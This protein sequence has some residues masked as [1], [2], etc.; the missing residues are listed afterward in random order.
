MN[1]STRRKARHLLHFLL[2]WVLVCTQIALPL[3]ALLAAVQP[4][5]PMAQA[6]AQQAGLSGWI[7]NAAG[8]VTAWAQ[9]LWGQPKTAAAQAPPVLQF[10]TSTTADGTYTNGA[11]IPICANYDLDLTIGSTLNVTLDTGATLALKNSGIAIGGTISVDSAYVTG[12]GP[13]SHVHALA[14][15]ADGK[16]IIGGQFT[17]Y[18]GTGRNRIARINTD[19][20]LDSSFTGS[21][22]NNYTEKIAIQADGKAIIVGH[23]TSVNGTGRNYIARLN[24]DGS[25]DTSFTPTLDNVPYAL[26]IQADGKI[27][28][29]GQ[30]GNVNG[31]GRT[32]LARLNSDGTLDTSFNPGSGLNNYTEEIV[33]QSDGKIVIGG[34]FTTVNG[35]SR[36]Y[37]ARLN[38]DGSLDTGFNPV[39]NNVPYAAALQS[40]GKIVFGG[41]FSTVNGTGRTRLARVNSDGTLDTSFDP[42]SGLNNYTEAILV[43]SDGQIIIGGHFTDIDGTARNR[44]AR[45]NANGSVDTTFAPGTGGNNVT[46]AMALQSD[47]KVVIGGAFTDFNGTARNYL[48]RVTGNANTTAT[49]A[50]QVCGTYTVRPGH[51]SADLTVSAITSAS[52]T[53][54]GGGVSSSTTLPSGQNLGDNENLVITSSAPGG[55]SANLA[56][57]YKADGVISTTQWD[58][59]SGNSKHMLA[60]GDGTAAR[61]PTLEAAPGAINNFNPRVA[62]L[63]N[64]DGNRKWTMT[65][66]GN[67]VFATTSTPGTIF[68]VS[69]FPDET[70]YDV[71]Q[72]Y[73]FEDDDPG[74]NLFTDRNATNDIRVVFQRDNGGTGSAGWDFVVPGVSQTQPLLTAHAW[75]YAA[76]GNTFTF[77]GYDYT[78]SSNPFIGATSPRYIF[79]AELTG[80][81]GEAHSG[82]TSE[83]I[84]YTTNWPANSSERKRINSYLAIKYGITLLGSGTLA[85]GAADATF[86]GTADYLNSASTVIWS[87]TTTNSSY[88]NNVAGIGR[89]DA[90]ALSQKQATSANSGFQPVIGLGTI[91]ASNVANSNTFGADKSFLMWG[92]NNQAASYG[93]SYTPTS[94]TPAAGYFRMNRVWKVQET[95][96]ITNVVVQAANADHLLV[97]SDPTF[98]TG[99]TEIAFS[100]G[101]ATVNFANGQFFTF[102]KAIT[103]PGAVANNLVFWSKAEDAGCAPGDACA[104]WDD[105]S[106]NG[107]PIETIGAMTLQAAD[108]AHNFHPYFSSFSTANYFKDMNSSFATPWPPIDVTEVSVFA[109]ARTNS[110]TDDGR[111][112]GMDNDDNFAGEPGLSIID[113]SPAFYRFSSGP[114]RVTLNDDVV[115]NTAAIFSARTAGTQLT[116]G[117]NGKHTASAITAG[118]GF[119]GDIFNIGY[120]TWDISGPFPGDIQEVIWYRTNVSDMERRRIESYLALK[121]GITLDQSTAQNYLAGD[122]TTVV[123]DATAHAAYS[124]HIAGIG[125]DDAYALNQKQATSTNPGFQPAIGLGTI[126]ASNAA[127]SNTFAAD[128]TFMVWGSNSSAASYGTTY[129][130]TSF[131]PAAGYYRMNRVWKVQ[132]TGTVGNVVVQAANADHL[133]VSSDPTFAT[134]VTEIAFSNGSATVNFANGQF[135]TFG[136]EL[137][138]PGGVPGAVAW[139]R[140][141]V[142]TDTTSDGNSVS[143]WV[144]NGSSGGTAGQLGSCSLPTFTEIKHNFNPAITDNSTNCNGALLLTNVFPTYSHHDLATFVVRSQPDVTQQRS[145]IAYNNN[146][147]VGPMDEAPWLA[148]QAANQSW[149][150]WA[151]NYAQIGTFPV[152]ANRVNDRPEINGLS[153]PVWSSGTHVTT[154]YLNGTSTT[155]SGGV[156]GSL[157]IGRNLFISQDS[158]GDNSS[159]GSTSEIV[160]YDRILS[161]TELQRVNSYL[162]IK[163]GLT[164]LNAGGTAVPDYLAADGTTKI[165]D[166]TAN[167]IYNSNIAGIGRDDASALKQKQSKSV[168]SGFQVTIGLG[169]IA[170]SNAANNN[171][172]SANKSF[173]LWG[174]NGQAASYG[175]SYTPS[176]FTPTGGY[177]RMNRIWKVQETGTIT[178]VVVVADGAEHILVSSDPTFATGV[179]E[180]AFSSGSATVNFANGQFFTFGA[181]ATAPGG[182]A[183]NLT[184]W[185]KANAGAESSSTAATD[186]VSVDAWRDQSLNGN[187][188]AQSTGTLKPEWLADNGKFNFNPSVTFVPDARMQ[189]QLSAGSWNNNDGTVYV[190][191]NQETVKTGWRNLVD[192]GLTA[193][194]SNNPQL[195]MSDNNRIATWMDGFDRDNTNWTPVIN[196]TRLI[197]YDWQFNV[198]GHSYYFD[199]EAFTGS[200]THKIGATGINI[201]NFA[202]IGGDPQLSEY[203]PGQIAEI[204]FFA[205]QHDAAKRARVQSY[206][207]IKYGITLDANPG[208]SATNFDY[209]HSGSTV[210]WAGNSTNSG[211]HNDVTGIG[212]DDASALDQRKSKSINGDDPIIIDNGAALSANRAFLVWGN[213]NGAVSLTAAYNGG[214]NNRLARVWKVQ[215]TGTMGG[216]QVVLPRSAVPN[217]GLRSLIVHSSDGAFGTVDRTY[218]LTVSGGNY[219]A[220]VDF[221]NGDFFTFS[222]SLTVPE[223]NVTPGTL[224]FGETNTGSTAPAQA[225]T[226]QNQGEVSLSLTSISLSGTDAARF[227][228][229]S[230]NCGASLSAGASCTVQLTFAPT[231]SGSR[232][233]LLVITNNDSDESTVNVALSGTTPGSGGGGTPGTYNLAVTKSASVSTA[234]V[235]VP[236]NYTIT[237]LNKGTIAA[238]NVTMT[239]QLPAGVTFG[240]ANATG[241]GTCTHSSGTVTCTWPSLA[242]GAT[243]TVTISVTP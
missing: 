140:A 157:G 225:V 224:D 41:Q 137:T 186:G 155:V 108:A 103:A 63:S 2:T 109:V 131:T 243:A 56:A 166:A 233:A 18:N 203:F 128:K 151:G 181:T 91:A 65:A 19:G 48:T 9:P 96:T 78:P 92:S 112:T 191:Y 211:Y 139:L 167:A 201:G 212:R 42:G 40:D 15:Q 31:T 236:F 88:H 159:G 86:G 7:A 180:I 216:V 217:I 223:I 202:N 219:I 68:N 185:Y 122:S 173:L 234:T 146:T 72:M 242:G 28:I 75:N 118:G 141:D 1:Q 64:A 165:W 77:N 24:T 87:G 129:T 47:G 127:N 79:G 125:R 3:G 188:A 62:F 198:G 34:H 220:T 38:S 176:S 102:G 71:P 240:A 111:I 138:G 120:G 149:F 135:F 171:T 221:N 126:A 11:A 98:A 53:S 10:F 54:T 83:N 21:G 116:V 232:S 231:T 207:A 105:R 124:N 45:L 13:N 187:D 37:L 152:A 158:N 213:N 100:S 147:A 6:V 197:G 134:G 29:G 229:S 81:G 52:V 17:S 238:S 196:E 168:N 85:G 154:L 179:T 237:V 182:V 5:P 49:P 8:N 145:I 170:A 16:A 228:I 67:N 163:Y 50:K 218:L 162:A 82:Y 94:F 115:V 192:F 106:L 55:V 161:A 123:W 239:D 30:F 210:I 194:D 190:I 183:G 44:L 175:A 204:V 160:A 93:V 113:G 148:S 51:N 184:A 33:V 227:A 95:G 107:N 114:G 189:A 66:S 206:L 174:D 208:S 142:G 235:G 27:V 178:N 117:L 144:N 26:A 215:E 61:M 46:Y 214:S 150:W 36:T 14:L 121:Y 76:G 74:L 195:G 222:S 133:L 200:A 199:G 90:S 241:G 104:D 99:V 73:A 22:L 25:L 20:S 97:S 58:D 80:G 110:L 132:E 69:S 59:V 209:V 32:R 101:S 169:A 177:Y 23:F 172:F 130:P 12:S 230:N 143:A 39:L 164:Y 205:E 226:I 35:T 156:N 4:T 119:A 136:R 89:D 193:S 84:V 70:V 60:A 153:L 43:Q 57:W